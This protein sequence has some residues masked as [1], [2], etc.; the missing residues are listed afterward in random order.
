MTTFRRILIALLALGVILG[1]APPVAA[2]P[3]LRQDNPVEPITL[4]SYNTESIVTFDPQRADDTPSVNAIENLFLGLTDI[5][6]LTGNI[7]PELATRW[8]VSENGRVWTFTLRDD[9]PWVQWNPNTREA[10]IVGT[11]TADD[12]VYA[13][14]RLCDPRLQAYYT[15]VASTIIQGCD[16]LAGRPPSDV[17]DADYELVEVY[18][19]DDTTVEI[20]LQYAASFFLDMSGMWIFHPVPRDVIHTYGHTWADVGTIVTNGPFLLDEHVDGERRVF[21]RNPYIPAALVGPGNV[22][23]VIVAQL[24]HDAAFAMYQAGQLDGTIVPWSEVASIRTDPT[25]APLLT[26]F[27]TSTVYY[28]GFSYDKPPFD[29]VHVRRAFGAIVDREQFIADHVPLPIV[30]PMIH[31]TPPGM[32][33]GPQIDEIGVGYDPE[34]ARAQLALAGFPGCEGFPAITLVTFVPAW[35]NYMAQQAAA[36]LGCPAD[37]FSIEVAESDTA[38]DL[39][40]SPHMPPDQR[41][42]LWTLAW[43][44]DYPD[45]HNWVG[46]V[47]SCG[48]ENRFRRPCAAVDDLIFQA[49][50][51]TDILTRTTLYGDIETRFF[52]PDGEHPLIPLFL[53]GG[54]MLDQPWDSAPDFDGAFGGTHYDWHTIDQ[55]MQLAARGG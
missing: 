54:I 22:E 37:L 41:P 2:G 49:A 13:V 8:V 44:P 31:F 5:D 20:H 28:I 42:M 4:Y 53:P 33:G 19:R 14:Q 16:D 10:A 34:Y 32:V 52:G 3:S 47:L 17:T 36:V 39:I 30:T 45:A 27:Y 25:L 38:V 18:A 29:N 55:A 15:G 21:V 40:L 24:A 48:P 43:T 26:E 11:V 7:T 9:V 50:T 23:R 6:P 46:N 12:V 51:E 35:G 1:L